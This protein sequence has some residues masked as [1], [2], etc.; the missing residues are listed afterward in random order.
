VNK[1]LSKALQIILPLALGIFLIWYTYTSFS[2]E[3][4]NETKE[5]FSE[6]AYGYVFLSVFISFLSHLVRAYRW[7]LLLE[8]LGYK[9]RVTNNFL[10]LSVGYLFNIFIPR[11]GEVSRALVLDKYEKI[12]FQKGFG[13]IISERVVD[14]ILL[15]LFTGL[16]LSLE[17]NRLFD[18]IQNHIPTSLLTKLIIAIALIGISIPLYLFFSKSKINQ[19]IKQFV[20][21]LKEGLFSILKMRRNFEFIILSLCIWILYVLSFYAAFQALPTTAIIPFGIVIISFVVGSFT[22]TFTH[23]GFGAYP[24][25]MAAILYVFEIS[26]T[27][28][29]AIGWI[30]WTS[31]IISLLLIGILSL[32]ILPV[33]NKI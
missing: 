8:P 29:I 21:G 27:V 20:F 5:F 1:T 19:R 24:V 3:Q 18:Y 16:A 22:L 10:A 25:A 6:A 33:Y 2:E 26:K 23:N 11:S 15:L 13:T 30:V 31:N 17:Y 14:L 32:L 28:G 9:P 4:L 7:N 12:P